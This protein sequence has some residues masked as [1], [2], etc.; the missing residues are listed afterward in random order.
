MA[1]IIIIIYYYIIILLLYYLRDS[2]QVPYRASSSKR[3]HSLRCWQVMATH[4]IWCYWWWQG[5]DYNTDIQL[6]LEVYIHLGWSHYNLFFNHSTNIL[7]T[8]Y[9][10]GKSVRTSTLCM[11]QVIFP[12]LFTDTLIHCITIPVGQKFTCTKLTVPLNSLGTSRKCHGFRSF[13]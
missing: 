10:F 9:S 3:N 7:L 1:Y 11:T 5:L 6:K 13:W 4:Q 8:N 12:T 2:F